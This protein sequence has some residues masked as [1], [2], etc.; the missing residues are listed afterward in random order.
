MPC[1]SDHMKQNPNEKYQQET[2]QLCVWAAGVACVVVP[3]NIRQQA[4]EYHA[5]DVGQ[6]RWLCG[7]MRRKFEPAIE[8][9]L[10]NISVPEARRLADWCEKH[11]KADEAR[12]AKE[13]QDAQNAALIASAASKLTEAERIAV[14]LK[15]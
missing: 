12:K 15:G 3:E 5:K 11:H 1:N 9:N 10:S 4:D 13:E 6:T 2:A 14:G 8:R 7:L